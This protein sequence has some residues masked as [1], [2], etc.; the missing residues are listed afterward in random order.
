MGAR[1]Q[2]PGVWGQQH[3][4]G[5]RPCRGRSCGAWHPGWPWPLY[6]SRCTACP[7]VSEA[8]LPHSAFSQPPSAIAVPPLEDAGTRGSH[9]T[10]SLALG[11]HSALPA[12]HSTL[13][14]G[15]YCTSTKVKALFT[16]LSED[17]QAR[18]E[19]GLTL[20]LSSLRTHGVQTPSQALELQKGTSLSWSEH[21]VWWGNQPRKPRPQPAV[22]RALAARSSGGS[23]LGSSQGRFPRGTPSS[24]PC[25]EEARVV[26][27]ARLVSASG[28]PWA[29]Q[30]SHLPSSLT[31][32]S[33]RPESIQTP[34]SA[35]QLITPRLPGD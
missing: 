21:A 11:S 3:L 27:N 32:K 25:P 7:P 30:Q 8:P 34:A 9:G 35:G 2:G 5:R 23:D 15:C 14:A 24:D 22:L 29:S 17:R 1:R 26:A 18:P 4:A 6:H 31:C 20:S 28:H 12:N 19:Q 16:P 13:P 33:V 10:F